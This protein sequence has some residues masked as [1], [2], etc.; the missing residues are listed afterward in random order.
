LWLQDTEDKLE[1]AGKLEAGREQGAAAHSLG[2]NTGEQ[3][4]EEVRP[5]GFR[6]LG[7]WR[8]EVE[9]K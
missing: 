7:A 3:E 2:S 6:R 9:C 8:P 4:E 5:P 1:A